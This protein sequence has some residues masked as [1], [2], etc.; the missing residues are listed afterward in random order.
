MFA[1]KHRNAAEEVEK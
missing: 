1:T